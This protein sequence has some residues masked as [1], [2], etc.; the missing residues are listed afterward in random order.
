MKR[1]YSDLV[2][3]LV[4]I[5]GYLVM[6]ISFM[7]MPL[8]DQQASPLVDKLPGVMFWCFLLIGAASQIVLAVRRRKW[9]NEHG[10]ERRSAAKGRIGLLS[11]MRNLPACL[12]DGVFVLSLVALIIAVVMTD[13]MGYLCYVFMACTVFSF[14]MH[15]VF[16]GKIYYF[17]T[18][19]DMILKTSQQKH[20]KKSEKE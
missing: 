9:L 15:C 20:Y 19:Q 6:S 3:F 14:C 7:I 16:N 4:S 17:L 18:H 10:I 1:K 2:W 12:A 5:F 13:G 11:F 8:I